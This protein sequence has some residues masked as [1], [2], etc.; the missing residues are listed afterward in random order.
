MAQRSEGEA[1]EAVVV[2]VA[3]TFDQPQG[4][5]AVDEPDGAVMTDEEGPGDVG[6]GRATMVGVAPDRQE[7]LILGRRH[8]VLGGLLLAEAAEAAQ[9]DPE[10]QDPGEDRKSVV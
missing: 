7:Q 6:D 8:V 2:D 1:D 9:C 3:A 10:L 5:G 4:L